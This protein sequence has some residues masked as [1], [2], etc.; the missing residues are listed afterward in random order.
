MLEL[1]IG[2]NVLTPFLELESAKE[3]SNL[4]GYLPLAITQA[5]SYLKVNKNE[6]VEHYLDLF[7]ENPAQV[8]GWKPEGA[9]WGYRNHTVLTTWEISYRAIERQFP[10]ATKILHL[11]GFLAR[12]NL[13]KKI[14]QELAM[15]IWK[16][17]CFRP[18]KSLRQR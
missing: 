4:L 16:G 8:L 17:H 7:K 15:S 3:L 14:L 10:D 1:G 6:T 11:C 13:D 12:E 2:S 5:G 18:D 9:A